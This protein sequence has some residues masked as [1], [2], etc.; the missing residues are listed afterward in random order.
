MIDNMVLL[1]TKGI[2]AGIET[3]WGYYKLLVHGGI[4]E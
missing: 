3:N 4:W 2:I 1:Q